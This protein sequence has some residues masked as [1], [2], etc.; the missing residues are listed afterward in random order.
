MWNNKPEE[1][2]KENTH[3]EKTAFLNKVVFGPIVPVLKTEKE[4]MR[5]ALH[6]PFDWTDVARQDNLFYFAQIPIETDPAE[7]VK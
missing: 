5:H 1:I 6:L 2:S 4:I 3:K 7:R